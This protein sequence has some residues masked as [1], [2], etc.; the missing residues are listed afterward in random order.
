MACELHIE[1]YNSLAPDE[2]GDVLQTVQRA[3]WVLSLIAEHPQGLTARQ[4]SKA[5]E[6]NTS[7]CYHLLNTLVMNG[8]LDRP[9]H[10]QIY[11]LDPQIPFLNNSLFVNPRKFDCHFVCSFP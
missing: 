6:L 11:L 3:L 10:Q 7:T 8:Y 5:L 9:P 2:K 1:G 4:I